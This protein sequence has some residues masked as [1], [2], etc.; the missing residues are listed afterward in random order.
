VKPGKPSSRVRQGLSRRDFA[1]GA[2]L[3]TATA[4]LSAKTEAQTDKPTSA[5]PASST[6]ALSAESEGQ[7]QAILRQHGN[8]LSE[9]QKN[10]IKRLLGE[11]QKGV[12]ALRAF[13]LENAD[14][15]ALTFRIY[16]PE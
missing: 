4:F 13:P 11:N 8:L 2:A 5:T 10:D 16:R 14:E 15:P 3:A 1:R 7:L 12:E 9:E 6:P